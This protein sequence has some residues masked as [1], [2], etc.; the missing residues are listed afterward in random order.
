MEEGPTVDQDRI[1]PEMVV[2]EE[3]PQ[4]MEA[5]PIEDQ[6]MK[7]SAPDCPDSHSQGMVW[8]RREGEGSR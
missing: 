2:M 5:T 8:R 1:G 3:G 6:L 7:V 4:E